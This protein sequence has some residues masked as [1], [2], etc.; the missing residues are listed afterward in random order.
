[1]PRATVGKWGKSLAVRIPG[2]LAARAGVADGTQVQ[3]EAHPGEIVVRPVVRQVSL[4][5][6]FQGKS[7]EQWRAAYAGAF[8][9]GPEVGRE[10]VEA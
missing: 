10:V 9:W 4:A 7:A 6:L 2:E 1:M 3:V 8:D 5:E